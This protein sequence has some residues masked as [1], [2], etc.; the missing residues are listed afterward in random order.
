MLRLAF[1]VSESSE[2]LLALLDGDPGDPQSRSFH[3]G[4]SDGVL[5]AIELQGSTS[6]LNKLALGAWHYSQ[7]VKRLDVELRSA[8]QERTGTSGGAYALGEIGLLQHWHDRLDVDALARVGF[9]SGAVRDFAT[10]L[11]V[12][13]VVRQPFATGV[14]ESLGLGVTQS[15]TSAALRRAQKAAGDRT[16]SHETAMEL[17][18]R[19]ALASW[20]AI[21]PD[22]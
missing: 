14:G 10:N 3:L 4:G 17:T 18:Y 12:G 20:F 6:T 8:A 15:R 13:I 9:A 16:A 2:L 7:P 21:Q 22:V 11:Q 19:R 1:Q 5:A